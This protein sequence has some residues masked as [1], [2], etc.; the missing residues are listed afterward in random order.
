MTE[1]WKKWEGQV[2]NG[3]FP[4]RQHLGGSDNSVVFLTEHKAKQIP[5]AAIKLIRKIPPPRKRNY[6]IGEPP[7]PSP[8]PT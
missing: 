7:P 2:V 8:I 3:N 5:S 4:L 1:A 6:P